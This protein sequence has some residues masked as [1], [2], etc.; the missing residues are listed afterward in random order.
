[1]AFAFVRRE[2][3][4]WALGRL[5]SRRLV[6]RVL[7]FVLLVAGCATAGA[8]NSGLTQEMNP[9]PGA[10][11]IA[12]TDKPVVGYRLI[13]SSLKR[14]S[15]TTFG[16]H[17]V[18]LSGNLQRRAWE[19]SA[20]QDLDQVVD[21]VLGQL[22]YDRL[23][24]QCE[25]LDCGSSHFWANEVFGTGRL[26]GRDNAQRYRVLL[27]EQGD[28]KLVYLLYVTHRGPRQTVYGVDVIQTRDKVTQG[29]VSRADVE[30]TLA[31]SQ[32]WLPGMVVGENGLDE[33]ASA[34]LID[35]L[36]GQSVSVKR[37]LY[38]IVHCYESTDMEA[39]QACS[40]RIAEQ[41]RLATFDGARQLDVRGQG[42]LLLPP[43]QQLTPAL[44]FVFWPTR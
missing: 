32:G 20:R 14:Q 22:D 11:S 26:V 4:S 5:C 41:L 40:D 39:N 6:S 18:A 28:Q 44:R 27:K 23:L 42:A 17:E 31:Q 21:F 34:A 12:N 3:F 25:D 8:A 2:K 43:D 19:I 9:W 30:K 16:E 1:M 33:A 36:K 15:A 13:T 29:E 35:T 37:R 10:R 24:Y 7:G 38:L